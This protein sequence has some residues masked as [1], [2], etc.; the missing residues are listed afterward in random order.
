ML[1]LQETSGKDNAARH[2]M[3]RF[4]AAPHGCF[5]L[6]DDDNDLRTPHQSDH[7]SSVKHCWMCLRH[8]P[9][10]PPPPFAGRCCC[11]CCA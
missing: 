11:H 3:E 10:L 8:R 1:P 9:H 4:D 5:L 7:K 6:C 2:L